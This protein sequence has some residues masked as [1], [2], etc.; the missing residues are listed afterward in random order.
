MTGGVEKMAQNGS[1][2]FTGKS[3][4][5]AEMLAKTPPEFRRQQI[6]WMSKNL[7]RETVL[8]AC[9]SYAKT[10]AKDGAELMKFAEVMSA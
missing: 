9:E 3:E 5:Y 2:G 6:I 8:K 4:I 10:G 7:Y 1:Y